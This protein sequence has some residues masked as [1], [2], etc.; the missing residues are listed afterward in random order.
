MRTICERSRHS[1][2]VQLPRLNNNPKLNLV[3]QLSEIFNAFLTTLG[4]SQSAPE[5]CFICEREG[6]TIEHLLERVDRVF[7]AVVPE[8]NEVFLFLSIEEIVRR[9]SIGRRFRE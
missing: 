9:I 6:P 4:S 7:D 8:A 5:L 3:L 2:S 1:S